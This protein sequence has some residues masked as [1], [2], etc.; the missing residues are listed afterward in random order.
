MRS[1]CRLAGSGAYTLNINQGTG[2][3]DHTRR[4][5]LRV[6]P[7]EVPLARA[8]LHLLSRNI[9]NSTS[10]LGAR[11]SELWSFVPCGIRR[12]QHVEPDAALRLLVLKV[13]AVEVNMRHAIRWVVGATV[14]LSALCFSA[15]DAGA[16]PILW[17]LQGVTF[18]DGVTAAGSFRF[19]A[20]TSTFS[21]LAIT[22]SN[23]FS[24]DTSDVN[25]AMSYWDQL[26]LVTNYGNA[27]VLGES[28]LS[29]VSSP[30]GLTAAGGTSPIAVYFASGQG[31][32]LTAN[33]D[34]TT[35]DRAIVSG[36]FVS[37]S[38]AV[39]VPEPASMLLLGTGLAG[40]GLRR[41]RQKR[42]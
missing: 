27:S 14:I 16:T 28:R 20:S 25:P 13:R 11:I 1:G 41:W 36:S 31:T 15:T 38:T 8:F 30:T 37:E 32:C 22:T 23:G 3:L 35:S 17:R 18:D 7:A 42:A 19:D 24:Y 4:V 29:F 6:S 9:C 40:A 21:D 26:W 2:D 39:P 12:T 34:V 5:Q 33:C 10:G